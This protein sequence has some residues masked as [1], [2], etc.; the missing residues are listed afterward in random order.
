MKRFGVRDLTYIGVFGGLWGAVEIWLGSYLRLIRMPGRSMFLIAV[1]IIIFTVGRRYVNRPGA[2]VMMAVVA[3]I[4]KAF[5]IGGVVVNPMLAIMM[6]GILAEMGFA[7]LGAG[8][9]GSAVA[10]TMAASWLI[11][12]RFVTLGLLG[13]WGFVETFNVVV[14][15]AAALLPLSESNVIV[16]LAVWSGLNLVAGLI[17]GLM[18][19]AVGQRVT[20]YGS[21]QLTNPGDR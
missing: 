4:L 13:G 3:S 7:I 12:H 21:S 20:A 5:S 8:L 6:E 10:G 1:A 19:Y 2:T 14:E 9:L 15:S 11:A 18:G 16:L 17:G